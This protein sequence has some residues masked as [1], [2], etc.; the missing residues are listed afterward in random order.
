MFSSVLMY[1]ILHSSL[2][3]PSLTKW[4]AM[5]LD[6]FFSTESGIVLLASTLLLS[7]RIKHGKSTGIPIVRSL[8]LKPL[9]YSQHCFI[10]M[11]SEP[12]VLVSMP[13]WRFENQYT[14][15]LFNRTMNPVLERRVT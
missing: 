4:Y 5:E 3:L 14:G 10:A 1:A 12:K 11:Y 9:K 2:A 15:A 6:F 8:Y 7:P 13:V